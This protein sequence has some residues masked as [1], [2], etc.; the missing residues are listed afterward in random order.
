MAHPIADQPTG[1]VGVMLVARNVGASVATA[2]DAALLPQA[3]V[4]QQA[5]GWRRA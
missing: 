3:V 2:D 4:A 1:F 5:A